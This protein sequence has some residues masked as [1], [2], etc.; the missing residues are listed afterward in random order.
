VA[1]YLGDT[2]QPNFQ[3]FRPAEDLSDYMGYTNQPAYQP[4]QPSGGI[5]SLL[6]N[7]SPYYENLNGIDEEL[8][9]YMEYQ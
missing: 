7:Y 5:G 3:S 9:N 6:Q 1:D 8:S 2:N 4:P